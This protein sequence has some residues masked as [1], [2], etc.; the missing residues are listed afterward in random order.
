MS[1]I[2]ANFNY[3]TQESVQFNNPVS[4]SALAAIGGAVNG[5]LS[6][7]LPVG[8][9]VDSMLTEAQFQ[10]QI[11]STNWVLADGGSCS[12]SEYESV[13]GNSTV[14]DLRAVVLRGKD[15]GRGLNPNGD[16][17]LGTYTADQ[18][19]SHAHSLTDPGHNHSIQAYTTAGNGAVGQA[20]P[21]TGTNL[22]TGTST[23]GIT[24]ANSGG[25]ETAPKTVTI[26]YFIRI[27]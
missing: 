13:T 15:N 19:A 12:G 7:L 6:V 10:T 4:E 27:N 1:N 5:L 23:T 25:S 26:N 2:T 20:F 8:S 3:V 9:I 24:M 21:G 16:L 11:G 22:G 17:A 14:P 18:Y